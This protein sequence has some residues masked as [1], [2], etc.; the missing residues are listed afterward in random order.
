MSYCHT[1]AY[2][3]RR[4]SALENKYS[5]IFFY[6]T[7]GPTVL[8]NLLS[9]NCTPGSDPV[10][11]HRCK[12]VGHTLMFYSKVFIRPFEKQSYYVITLGVRL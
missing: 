10:M 9:H 8:S 11:G 7:T 3:V 1:N 4:P 5:N 6:K 2:V 12:K